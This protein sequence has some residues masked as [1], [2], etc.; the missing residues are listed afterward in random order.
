MFYHSAGAFNQQLNPS[1]VWLLSINVFNLLWLFYVHIFVH[2]K[3]T[4]RL[5]PMPNDVTFDKFMKD[6]QQNKN[7]Y[8]QLKYTCKKQI[9]ATRQNDWMT[10][11]LD[12]ITY[13]IK[14]RENIQ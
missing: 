4:S 13:Y 14:Q 7:T 12:N 1:D 10:I 9:I 8:T 11:W 3:S 5:V 6:T 2:K